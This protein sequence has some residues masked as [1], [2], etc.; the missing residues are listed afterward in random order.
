VEDKFGS[1]GMETSVQKFDL[2]AFQRKP[3]VSAVSLVS[4][5]PENVRE[6]RRN[7]PEFAE[8]ERASTKP[9][10]APVL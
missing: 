7:W 1:N 10:L 6:V 8:N 3:N 9:A 5:A 4:L 2:R